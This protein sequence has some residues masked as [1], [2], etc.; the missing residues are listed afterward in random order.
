[1][2]IVPAAALAGENTVIEGR[3]LK[4]ESVA[5]PLGVTREIIPDEPVS[6]TALM[7]LAEITLNDVAVVLPKLT[8]FV[9][10]KFVPS[11]VMVS[12]LCPDV[13]LND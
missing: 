12:P 3:K 4:P 6:N 2:I 8:E 10:R 7:I 1:V 11:I 13:G 9:P 5:A